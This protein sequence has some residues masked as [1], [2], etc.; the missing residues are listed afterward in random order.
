MSGLQDLVWKGANPRW[1]GKQDDTCNPL[2]MTYTTTRNSNPFPCNSNSHTHCVPWEVGATGV[3][4]GWVAWLSFLQVV[5]CPLYIGSGSYTQFN[6][7]ETECK[8]TRECWP[9]CSCVCSVYTIILTLLHVISNNAVHCVNSYRST[10]WLHPRQMKNSRPNS[11]SIFL[12]WNEANM[13]NG[14]RHTGQR[15][16]P[17]PHGRV[18]RRQAS[19]NLYRDQCEG[20]RWV[21]QFPLRYI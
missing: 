13:W 12:S 9:T 5:W 19:Q 18:C 6:N 10:L 11:L 15:R 17:S 14:T 3:N 1:C 7:V 20:G 16:A 4:L 2:H 8:W 21:I